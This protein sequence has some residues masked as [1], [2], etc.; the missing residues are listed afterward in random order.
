MSQSWEPAPNCNI[1]EKH[2]KLQSSKNL[3]ANLHLSGRLTKVQCHRF[4][5][6]FD[7]KLHKSHKIHSVFTNTITTCT[8][9]EKNVPNEPKRVKLSLANHQQSFW[10]SNSDPCNSYWW[11]NAFHPSLFTSSWWMLYSSTLHNLKP[12]G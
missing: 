5:H 3:S 7:D 11:A 4:L 1:S 8:W 6:D 12:S 9:H 10:V 2:V